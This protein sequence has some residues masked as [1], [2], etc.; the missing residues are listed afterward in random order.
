VSLSLEDL[1]DFREQM[2]VP[3]TVLEYPNWRWKLPMALDELKA[4]LRPIGDIM[5]SAGR[6]VPKAIV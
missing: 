3:G 1:A 4:R 2:N 6:G 5:K